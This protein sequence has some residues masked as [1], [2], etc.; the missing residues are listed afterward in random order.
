MSGLI[1]CSNIIHAL[2]HDVGKMYMNLKS[3]AYFNFL[4]NETYLFGVHCCHS[5]EK[6][7]EDNNCFLLVFH[8]KLS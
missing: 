2:E 7:F 4:P 3:R 8:T 5:D 6:R 1:S